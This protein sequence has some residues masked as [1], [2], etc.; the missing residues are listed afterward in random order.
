MTSAAGRVEPQLSHCNCDRIFHYKP[1]VKLG[2]Q[3]LYK[4]EVHINKVN[5]HSHTS[6]QDSKIVISKIAPYF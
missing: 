6:L 4:H 1:A 3:L 2:I 5:V